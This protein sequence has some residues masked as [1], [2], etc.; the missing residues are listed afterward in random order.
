MRALP[1][2]PRMRPGCL[3]SPLLFDIVLKVLVIS[4]RQV[5]DMKKRK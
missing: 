5:K 4:I 1:L 3:L 2:K